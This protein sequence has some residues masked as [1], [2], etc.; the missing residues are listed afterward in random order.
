MKSI[1]FQAFR[2]NLLVGYN[3]KEPLIFRG[4]LIAYN[5]YNNENIFVKL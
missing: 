2:T 1:Y 3:N 5:K 4:A